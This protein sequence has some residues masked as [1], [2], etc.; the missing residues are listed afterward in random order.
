[1][2]ILPV[3][4]WARRRTRSRPATLPTLHLALDQRIARRRKLRELAGAAAGVGM[5]AFCG[6][7]VA[8][9]DFG[10]RQ[11]PLDGKSEQPPVLFLRCR[12][13]C[14]LAEPRR[15]ERVHRVADDAKTPP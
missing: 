3:R 15:V 9:L 5:Q 11:W 13:D 7:L 2:E 10:V 8:L 1:M 12:H 14:A 4:W 6:A